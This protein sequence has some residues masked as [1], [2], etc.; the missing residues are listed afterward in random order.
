M[1][2]HAASRGSGEARVR[3]HRRHAASAAICALTISCR[4]RSPLAAFDL[5]MFSIPD[6]TLPPDRV[7]SF[8][9]VEEAR[10]VESDMNSWLPVHPVWPARAHA[11]ALVG[12]PLRI[13]RALQV[14]RAT[15]ARVS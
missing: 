4:D 14:N 2:A 9:F 10:V 7:N 3:S 5:V 15:P 11:I 6:V 12:A 13:M 1:I 8:R